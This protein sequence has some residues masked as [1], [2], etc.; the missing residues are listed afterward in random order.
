[1]IVTQTFEVQRP[2]AVDGTF[3]ASVPLLVEQMRAGGYAPASVRS[4]TGLV[5]DFAKWLDQREICGRCVEV[6]LVDEY[7]DARWQHRRRRRGDAFTLREFLKLVAVDSA[8]AIK[9]PIATL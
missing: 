5:E 7:L 1:M 9:P 3:L 6:K 8:V 2:A 4:S